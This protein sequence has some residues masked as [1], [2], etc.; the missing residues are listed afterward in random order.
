MSIRQAWRCGTCGRKATATRK[1]LTQ[2][3]R[4]KNGGKSEKDS[5]VY[6]RGAEGAEEGGARIMMRRKCEGG[7]ETRPYRFK[8]N[9]SGARLWNAMKRQ[10]GDWRSQVVRRDTRIVVVALRVSRRFLV[11]GSAESSGVPAF[12]CCSGC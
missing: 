12:G 5:G 4:R 10:S 2:R 6:R 8:S 7:S 11:R 9:F 1:D 3:A